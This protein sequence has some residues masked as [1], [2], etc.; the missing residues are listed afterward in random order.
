MTMGKFIG[1]YALPAVEGAMF[2]DGD[3]WSL[4]EVTKKQASLFKKPEGPA[5]GRK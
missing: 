3:A 4:E 1:R 2:A 5:F